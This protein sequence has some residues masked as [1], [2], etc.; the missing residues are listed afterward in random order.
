MNQRQARRKLRNAL[1]AVAD[2]MPGKSEDDSVSIFRHQVAI[3]RQKTLEE[4][5]ATAAEGLRTRI[6][7]VYAEAVEDLESL[8]VAAEIDALDHLL[9][10]APTT[11]LESIVANA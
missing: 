1:A 4:S 10:A 9:E 3:L 11:P 7:A 6:E 2:L 8:D 5:I